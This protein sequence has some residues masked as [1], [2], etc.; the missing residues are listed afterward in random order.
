VAKVDA[1]RVNGFQFG[2]MLLFAFA[3]WQHARHLEKK[4]G[5]TPFNWPDWAWAVV[6]GLSLLIGIVLLAF[7]ERGLRKAPGV[8]PQQPVYGGNPALGGNPAFGA[9]PPQPAPVQQPMAVVAAVPSA[10]APAPVPA[11]PPAGWA[12]DPTG[13]HQL[14]WWDGTA[15]TSAV[16]DDGV[17]GT[18]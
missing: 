15:W 12:V 13:R 11:L 5:R 9:W 3:G 1:S 18:D 6:C 7:A 4:Y 17:Q 8:V 10:P 14:R 2:L 16:H